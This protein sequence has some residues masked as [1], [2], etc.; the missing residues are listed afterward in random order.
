MRVEDNGVNA[1]E[2]HSCRTRFCLNC[3]RKRGNDDAARLG[4][5]EGVD[6]GTLAASDVLV[7][8]VP[9]LWVDR[10]AYSTNNS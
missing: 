9:S 3:P 6:D 8:P 2:R 10:L 1:K 7:V 5:P 4:L